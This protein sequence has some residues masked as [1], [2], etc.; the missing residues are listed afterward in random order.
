VIP[1]TVGRD[2]SI[3][4]VTDSYKSDKLVGVV[5]QKDSTIEE[6]SAADLEKI[7]TVAK[8][9]KLIKMTKFKKLKNLEEKKLT[10]KLQIIS[11]AHIHF[12][13]INTSKSGR[14][15]TRKPSTNKR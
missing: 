1:I 15:S 5:A 2:K 12:N 4:A 8:I 10:G 3:K 9:V 6:P 13:Q 7:G 11:F 14:K